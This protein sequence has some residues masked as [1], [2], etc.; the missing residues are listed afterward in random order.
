MG[1]VLGS[2]P[3][4]RDRLYLGEDGRGHGSRHGPQ[5][6]LVELWAVQR[7]GSGGSARVGLNLSMS[8]PMALGQGPT[9]TRIKHVA[10]MGIGHTRIKHSPQVNWDQ[11]TRSLLGCL[12]DPLISSLIQN[13]SFEINRKLSLL[14]LPG[15][16][17]FSHI[18]RY[19]YTFALSLVL[20]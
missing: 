10:W 20:A 16:G 6:T 18:N 7:T 14:C 3:L 5:H 8:L 19:T 17:S 11:S 4:M 15:S 1:Q 2:L 9:H 12:K 13:I